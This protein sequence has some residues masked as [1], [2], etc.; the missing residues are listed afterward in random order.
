MGTG[1]NY[2]DTG[3]NECVLSESLLPSVFK[4]A[5]QSAT[6]TPAFSYT[7]TSTNL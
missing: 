1:T 5:E 4:I 2:K 7:I 6:I 3:T